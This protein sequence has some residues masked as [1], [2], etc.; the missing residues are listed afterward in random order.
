LR[1]TTELTL[2]TEITT[3]AV[4]VLTAPRESVTVSFA[5]KSPG[6]W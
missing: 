1:E 6:P 3:T 2:L 5:A 4:F